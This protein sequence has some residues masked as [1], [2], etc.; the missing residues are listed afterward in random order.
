MELTAG[1]FELVIDGGGLMLVD[2]LA[3]WCGPRRMF[4]PVFERAS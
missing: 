1:N 2:F 4:A 3:G